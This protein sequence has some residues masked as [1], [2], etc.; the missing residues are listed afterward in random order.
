VV[1]G[2]RGVLKPRNV[3]WRWR[4]GRSCCSS[5]RKRRGRVETNE[6]EHSA[7]EQ[8]S[9]KGLRL[10]LSLVTG[11]KIKCDGA[12]PSPLVCGLLHVHSRSRSL[13]GYSCS[14]LLLS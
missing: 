13:P 14:V 1:S 5:K 11:E 7:A 6:A 3:K 8:V 2:L 9:E 10:V 4:R 12:L